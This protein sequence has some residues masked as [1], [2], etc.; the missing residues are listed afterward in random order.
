M[1][2]ILHVEN[3][4]YWRDNVVRVLR[5]DHEVDSVGSYEDAIELLDAAES[6]PYDLVIVDLNLVDENDRLG[7]DLLDHLR[8]VRRADRIIVMTGSLPPGPMLNGIVL[9]YLVDEVILKARQGPMELRG[10]VERVLSAGRDR[11]R[12]HQISV[13]RGSIADQFESWAVFRGS[14]IAD[15]VGGWQAIVNETS[16]ST[17]RGQL[18]RAALPV[19][20]S[21]LSQYESSRDGIG[22]MLARGENLLVVRSALTKADVEVVELQRQLEREFGPP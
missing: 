6:H 10:T 12:P 11:V 18:A 3:E 2:K 17:H 21:V 20:R 4:L 7:L 1:A 14:A 5:R 22:A 13:A 9:R 19:A 8:A 16:A 15:L